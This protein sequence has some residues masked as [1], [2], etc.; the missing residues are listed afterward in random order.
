MLPCLGISCRERHPAGF[1]AIEA[2]LE[3]VLAGAGQGH[4]EHQHCPG[5]DINDARRRLAKLHRALAAEQLVPTLVD[6][7]DSDCVHADLGA[8]HAHPENQVGARLHRR[9]IGQPDMLK[10]AQHAELALLI[11]QGVVRDDGKIE[12]QLS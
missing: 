5:L 6:K 3:R 9:E 8:A 7:T 10:H 4:I 11:D 2:D 12:V 1:L